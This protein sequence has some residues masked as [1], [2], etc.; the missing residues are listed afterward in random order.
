MRIAVHFNDSVELFVYP[1][2]MSPPSDDELDAQQAVATHAELAA[3][4]TPAA[5]AAP[6]ASAAAQSYDL[7]N[8]DAEVDLSGRDLDA[9]PP[10]DVVMLRTLHFVLMLCRRT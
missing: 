9:L 6:A 7:Y 10:F 3:P 1:H 8:G 4:G 2:E 5:P